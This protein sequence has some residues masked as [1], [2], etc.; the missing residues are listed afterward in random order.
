MGLFV[1]L[2]FFP[3]FFRVIFRVKVG[4]LDEKQHRTSVFPML[5][6]VGKSTI[7]IFLG[8]Q[9]A[10]CPFRVQNWENP[11]PQTLRFKGKMSYLTQNNAKK[12]ENAKRTDRPNSTHVQ[13]GA[14]LP[15]S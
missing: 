1:L 4:Q 11:T 6:T 3:L 12:E 7:R 10:I 9:C 2:A 5:Q 15:N 8:P 13:G 14:R